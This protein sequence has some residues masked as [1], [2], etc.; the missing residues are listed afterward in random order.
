M[1]PS[2]LGPPSKPRAQAKETQV[3]QMQGAGGR[4]LFGSPRSSCTAFP[5]ARRTPQQLLPPRSGLFCC[6]LSRAVATSALAKGSTRAGKRGPGA[7]R[8]AQGTNAAE[9]QPRRQACCGLAS[10]ERS[11]SPCP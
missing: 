9:V 3:S 7:L 5:K 10:P 6:F 1:S 4:L 11:S 8:L 2:E